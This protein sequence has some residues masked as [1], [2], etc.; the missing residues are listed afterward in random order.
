[1]KSTQATHN[2]ES[3]PASADLRRIGVG[4][5]LECWQDFRSS[6]LLQCRFEYF[7]MVDMHSECVEAG[8]DLRGRFPKIDRCAV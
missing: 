7:R 6:P 3:M 8:F 2:I 5:W 1:M 4:Y